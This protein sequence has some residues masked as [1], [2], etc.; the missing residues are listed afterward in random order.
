MSTLP[1]AGMDGGGRAATFAAVAERYV[2]WAEDRTRPW[3]LEYAEQLLLDLLRAGLALE[4]VSEEVSGTP[5]HDEVTDAEWRAVFER[6]RELPFDFYWGAL[7]PHDFERDPAIGTESLSDDLADVYRDV[8][9]GLRA[10]RAGRA[11]HAVHEWRFG[12]EHHW[13]QHAANAVAAIREYAF[14]GEE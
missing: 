9:C 6:G 14:R 11:G 12:H 8:L 4:A 2:G 1:N 10:W 13:G 7:A 3:A 5:A